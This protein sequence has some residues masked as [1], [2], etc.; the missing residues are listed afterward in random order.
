MPLISLPMTP[1]RL[2]LTWA[3]RL[4]AKWHVIKP[5]CNMPST[6][7]KAEMEVE[8]GGT[9]VRY[10][11][12]ANISDTLEDGGA[13][14]EWGIAKPRGRLELQWYDDVHLLVQLLQQLVAQ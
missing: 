5:Y 9:A 3:T 8:S 12:F 13:M 1:K 2:Q 11:I 6:G 14:Q 4:T 7:L 10:D